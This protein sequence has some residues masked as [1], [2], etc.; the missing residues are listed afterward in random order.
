MRANADHLSLQMLSLT[1]GITSCSGDGWSTTTSRCLATLSEAYSC[2][3]SNGKA[4][5][6][7]SF[8]IFDSRD[9]WASDRMVSRNRSIKLPE[10]LEKTIR[11]HQTRNHISPESELCGDPS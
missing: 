3:C 1:I 2:V 10:I 6:S 9:S 5:V 8:E 4:L 11:G 7:R